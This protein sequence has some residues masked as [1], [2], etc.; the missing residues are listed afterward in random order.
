MAARRLQV[1]GRQ[2]VLLIEKEYALARHLADPI[3]VRIADVNL[4]I[5][6]ANSC[7]KVQL[8]ILQ[9]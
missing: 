8:T 1:P 3:P 2:I 4:S 9:R 6:L 5:S 7:T